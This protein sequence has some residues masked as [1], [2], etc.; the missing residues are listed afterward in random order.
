VGGCRHTE[1]DKTKERRDDQ[2]KRTYTPEDKRIRLLN[3]LIQ[4][5]P[6][7]VNLGTEKLPLEIKVNH[8]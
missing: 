7:V 4:G 1:R 6:E 3:F 2:E 5:G 8:D